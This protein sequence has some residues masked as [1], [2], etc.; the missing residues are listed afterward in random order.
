MTD[1]HYR[2]VNDIHIY[3]CLYGQL[4]IKAGTELRISGSGRICSAGGKEFPAAILEP[5]TGS[6]RPI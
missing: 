4:Y 3:N 5:C 6:I 1:G 2:T